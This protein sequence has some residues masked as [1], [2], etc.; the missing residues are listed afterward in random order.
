[1]WGGRFDESIDALMARFNHS[2]RFDQRMWREDI[3]GSMAWARQ[4]A[5]AGV[6]SA[7]ERD[8]LLA[9]LEA[10]FAEF[11]DGRFEA[12]PS[13]EDIHTAVERRLGEL[14]G[15]VA[16]KLH[17]GRS[18]NDQV[19]TDVRLW[20]M[21]A[22]QRIDDGVRALQQALLTQAEA[23]GDALMP[24]YTHLQRAQPVLL[25]H[26]LLSHFWSLQR[27]RERLADCAKRTAVLPL[28]SGAIAGTPLAIDRQALA[29]DLGMAAISPNSM[30][31]VSDRDFIAEF[32][33]CAAL[34]GVHLSRLAEDMIIYSSAEFG[35]VTLADAYSTGSSLMPQK[36][37][38]DSFEL[39]RGKAGRLIGDL[40][41]LLIVLKGLPSA[42]NKDLQEDKEPLFDAADTLE[43][44]LPVAAGAVATARFRYEH[45][46]AALDNAML[47]TDVADYLVARGV[48]FREAHHVVGRLVR[49]AEQ[50]G[51][52]LS[53]LP[54]DVFLAAHPAC[55]A[56]VLQV[57]NVDR[58]VAQRRVP[59]AT[60]PEAVH[61]QI[62]QARR[63]M[64]E[65]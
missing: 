38:P 65:R 57:F 29:A 49:E 5:Q 50:R 43:L 27:D 40:A 16:G 45:M 18:R 4:L 47:A 41:T 11:A 15:P 23:A 52:A 6:I 62:V 25:A 8:T 12:R 22:I 7:E 54:L 35:F 36:K 42:Y 10:V 56:D 44:A 3:R 61:E 1:M 59:G 39:L 60:A 21:G 55:G 46:R 53:A 34:I 31:A 14:V 17:T 9:G 48:P 24:G 20:T 30:D 26:W 32:L 13:D 51:V 64:T 2:F 37:N 58:S 28:G 19:A 63:C 33:F